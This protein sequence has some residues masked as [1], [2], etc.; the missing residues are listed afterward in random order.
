[1]SNPRNTGTLI[2]RLARDPKVFENADGSKKVL[3][4]VMVDRDYTVGDGDER[5]RPSD[6]IP[7]EAFYGK[8][9]P[10]T[11]LWGYVH[12]GDLIGVQTTLQFQ[13]Y[14]KGSETVYE[15]KVI[16]ESI[17]ALEPKSVTTGRLAERAAANDHAA[18]AATAAV[19]APVA[20]APAPVRPAAQPSQPAQPTLPAQASQAGQAGQAT[21]G[22]D[23]EPSP[24]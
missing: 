13:S 19:T 1:M 7:V 20:P 3:A 11:G 8:T 16:A 18:A 17:T 23:A 24:F 6:G 21:P 4:T 2:G 22:V 9:A 12:K 15:T 10:S 14:D 5:T